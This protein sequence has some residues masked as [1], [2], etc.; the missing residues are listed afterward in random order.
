MLPDTMGGRKKIIVFVVQEKDDVSVYI[1]GLSKL[2][3]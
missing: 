2:A 1:L 3:R